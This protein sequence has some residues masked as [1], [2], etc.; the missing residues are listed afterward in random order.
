MTLYPFSNSFGLTLILCLIIAFFMTPSTS[1]PLAQVCINSKNPRFCLDVFALNTYDSPY[2]LTI[3]AI[4]LTL[5]TASKTIKKIH[6]LIDQI[7]DEHLIDIYNYCLNFYQFVIDYLR[8]TEE[9]FL[10][11][12]QCVDVND[13]GMTAQVNAFRC[14]K[15][16]QRKWGYIYDSTLT[17][18]NKNL[19]IFGS[20]IVSA[21]DLLYNST[22]RKNS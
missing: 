10:K 21:T 4:N 3:V 7:E 1:N 20:I 5:A 12:K 22:L 13:A 18:E 15:E 19:S 9:R 2:E 14:E 11:E 8:S 16:F 6:T 17:K